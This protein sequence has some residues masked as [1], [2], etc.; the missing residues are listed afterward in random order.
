MTA[1]RVLRAMIIKQLNGFSYE[2]LARWR[3]LKC[4]REIALPAGILN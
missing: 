2:E 1:E 3:K 4:L